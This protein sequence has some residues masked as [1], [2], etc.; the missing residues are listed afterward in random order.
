MPKIC[1]IGHFHRTATT[2]D[3][4]WYIPST[5]DVQYAKKEHLIACKI[6][7]MWELLDTKNKISFI[8][9]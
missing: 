7:G 5:K 1:E 4:K 2:S 9:F 8:K 6:K 3:K